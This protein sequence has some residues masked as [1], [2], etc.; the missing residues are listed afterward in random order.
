MISFA[1]LTTLLVLL[2]PLCG[3]LNRND[4]SFVRY[5]VKNWKGFGSVN[6]FSCPGHVIFS[7]L[8]VLNNDIILFRYIDMSRPINL[9]EMD[10]E[11]NCRQVYV[12]DLSCRDA[13]KII[14]LMSREKFFVTFCRSVL[15]IDPNEDAF[16]FV[17]VLEPILQDIELTVTSDV[18]YATKFPINGTI[19]GNHDEDVKNCDFFLYD[20]W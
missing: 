18:V 4:I 10:R 12:V 13:G 1:S 17:K 9:T 5:F 7:D 19:P 2:L 15:L 16:W 11:N 20:I 6:I 14:H 8:Y 3:A